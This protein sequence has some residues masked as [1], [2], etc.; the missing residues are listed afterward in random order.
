MITGA[1]GIVLS[2][3]R[4]RESGKILRVFTREHG[5]LPV[6]AHGVFKKNSSLLSVTEWFSKSLFDLEPGRNFYYLRQAELADLHYPLRLDYERIRN[7][8]LAAGF[9][10]RAI[11][12]AHPQEDLYDLLEEF[13]ALL[14]G[15]SS[16]VQLGTA[17]LL[18]AARR[19]GYQPMLY[20]CAGCGNRKIRS[21]RFSHRLGGIVCENCRFP[22]EYLQSFSKSS[23]MNI[24][25]LMNHSLKETAAK[26]AP[27]SAH[28]DQLLVRT[29]LQ[30]AM[31]WSVQHSGKRRKS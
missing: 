25:S 23:Y 29:Y 11:P 6:M 19:M 18:Q 2:G 14:V 15:A 7:A 5:I 17:F 30:S 26:T 3:M 22:G 10:L 24:Y 28:Q 13:L 31:G 4:Y 20:A 9:L 16:P 8:Q 1:K 21:M 12:E 27:E